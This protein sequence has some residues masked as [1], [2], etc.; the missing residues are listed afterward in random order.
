[1]STKLD[2][3]LAHT[4]LEVTARKAAADYG[5][6]ERK[7]SAHT[8]RGFTQGLRTASSTGPA[9]IAE[10]K[11]AS[12]SKGLIRADFHP[13]TLARTFQAAGAAALS[14][15][16]DEEFFQGSLA[17]LEQ[18]SQVVTIPCLRKDFILDPFQI[19]E[20]RAHGADAILLIVASHTD[21]SLS[22]LRDEAR[23]L[24]L[25]VLCETHSADEL[26]RAI[27]LGFDLIGVN[28]R[29]LRTFNVRTEIFH[30]LASL[31]PKDAVMVAESGIR[32]AEDIASFR[33]SGY[34]AFLIG[35]SLMRQPDPAAALA[36]LLDREYS[37][38]I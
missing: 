36:T 20:A 26:K 14:V 10:I 23:T 1:M 7:A 5:L 38:D 12:P 15:L 13:A 3:I 24:G 25:D 16:T 2:Q 11:K 22:D 34:G 33:Q 29:D 32:N 8:P 6:L 9:I 37:L 17:Y 4:L 27:D 21:Q 18:A 35:E 30:E 31:M 28:S 19:L